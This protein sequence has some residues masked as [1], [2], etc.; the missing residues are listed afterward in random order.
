MTDTTEVTRIE[1][2]LDKFYDKLVTI[3]WKDDTDYK[4]RA[5]ISALLPAYIL[6]ERGEL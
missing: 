2:T 1:K 4:M 6:M 3:W 5:R